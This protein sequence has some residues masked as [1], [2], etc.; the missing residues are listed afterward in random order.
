LGRDL[1]KDLCQC[2]RV[3][4]QLYPAVQPWSPIFPEAIA[5]MRTTSARGSNRDNQVAIRTLGRP[6]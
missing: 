2:E 1:R 6:G 4:H 3:A 5:A